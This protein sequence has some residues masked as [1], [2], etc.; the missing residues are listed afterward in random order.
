MNRR[1]TYKRPVSY[2]WLVGGLSSLISAL[3]VTGI[4]LITALQK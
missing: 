1:Q 2:W 4:I 3:V